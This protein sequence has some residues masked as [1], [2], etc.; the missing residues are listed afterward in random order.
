MNHLNTSFIRAYLALNRVYTYFPEN[1]KFK[2]KM[3]LPINF[4]K[5]FRGNQ[6]WI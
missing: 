6:L 3:K 5:L 1:K 4:I 2:F